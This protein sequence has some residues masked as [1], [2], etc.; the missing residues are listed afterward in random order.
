LPPLQ[1][2][3]QQSVLIAHAEPVTAQVGA[4]TQVAASWEL[5]TQARV[6]HAPA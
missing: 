2:L 6:Q 5:L 4:S 3:L 1:T